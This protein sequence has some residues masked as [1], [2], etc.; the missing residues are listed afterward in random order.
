[1]AD[2][3]DHYHQLLMDDRSLTHPLANE[4]RQA[5]AQSTTLEPTDQQLKVFAC[6]WWNKFGFVKDKATCTWVID[7]IDPEHFVDF[8]R[9]ALAQWGSP[10][11]LNN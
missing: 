1:M 8:L 9:D 10:S 6:E 11:N 3:L 4:A 2:Q 7:E 5:L